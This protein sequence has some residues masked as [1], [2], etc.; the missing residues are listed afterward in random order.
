MSKKAPGLY[1]QP[2]CKTWMIS[3]YQN[4]KKIRE[5]TGLTDFQAARQ[6]RNQRLGKIADGEVIDLK[7]NR[8]TVSDLAKA[9]LTDYENNKKSSLPDVRA[10]WMLHIQPVLG[11]LRAIQITTDVLNNY[12]NGRLKEGAENATINREMA[13]LKR[14]FNLAYRHSTPRKV[15]SVPVF[16]TLEE[17]PPRKGFIEADQYNVLRQN[18]NE[19]WIRTML[20][21]AFNFGFRRGELLGLK[22]RQFDEASR[23]LSLD[24]GSTKNGE[25]RE[26]V[27][28][29]E[30]FELVKACVDDKKPDDFI[31]TRKT[32]KGI[33][34]V[35]DLRVAWWKLCVKS[36]VGEMHCPKCSTVSKQYRHRC[37]KVV[38]TVGDKPILCKTELKYRGLILHDNRRSAVRRMV[39]S[40][41]PEKVAQTISGHLSRSVFERYNIVSG[42]D[43]RDAA[44][45]LEVSPDGHDFG[46]DAT[47]TKQISE[48]SQ[49]QTKQARVV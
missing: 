38:A 12:I 36:G 24:P 48:Q 26:V 42:S 30:C 8:I 27:L 28:T 10:R 2:G 25:P 9:V 46:H 33:T 31:L 44:R 7:T 39:R 41:I 49:S 15:Q 23:A 1:K 16:P 21:L 40:G 6:L 3:Y 34:E 11:H 29:S 14:A 45:K 19:L 18:C 37:A 35:K 22:V 47:K 5:S 32:R 43:L 4:G 20:A 17:N 13:F